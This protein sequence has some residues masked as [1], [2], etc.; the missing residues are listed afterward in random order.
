MTTV[1]P[2]NVPQ[3]IEYAIFFDNQPYHLDEVGSFCK[4]TQLVH[5]NQTSA[6]GP[7]IKFDSPEFNTY[8]QRIDPPNTFADYKVPEGEDY[9]SPSE[10][11]VWNNLYVYLMVNTSRS[12]SD[13]IDILSGIQELHMPIVDAWLTETPAGSARVALFDWDRTISMVEGLR[14]PF[15]GLSEEG[16]KRYVREGLTYICGGDARIAMLRAMFQKLH[17]AGVMLLILTNNSACDVEPQ[18]DMFAVELFQDIP[19]FTICSLKEPYR[20]NKGHA[21]LAHK[22]FRPMCSLP[23]PSPPPHA[24]SPPPHAPSP[25]P[26]SGGGRTRKRKLKRK[27]KSR[28]K[29]IY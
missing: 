4:N 17:D 21:L 2:E 14:I 3:H 26:Q 25:P 23:A 11:G 12:Q 18:F 13:A 24:P 15:P 20:G 7:E 8:L 5:I 6:K 29:R 22:E 1:A 27:Q 10:E 19:F 16:L 28:K 9:K